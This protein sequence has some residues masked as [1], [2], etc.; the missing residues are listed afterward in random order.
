MLG[1]GTDSILMQTAQTW[2]ACNRGSRT[3]A[4]AS[5]GGAQ[6]ASGLATSRWCRTLFGVVI[7]AGSLI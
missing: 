3:I 4:S 6:R 7:V 2:S 5:L 1:P